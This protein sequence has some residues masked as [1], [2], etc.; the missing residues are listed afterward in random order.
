MT[1]L[2]PIAAAESRPL[3]L[4]WRE[5]APLPDPVGRKG[6]FAGVSHGHGLLAG[7]SNFPVP[8]RAGGKKTF[9][10]TVYVCPLPLADSTRW[11]SVPD[12]L[13]SPL[14][15]GASVVTEKGIACLG[16][17]D[18]TRPV[19]SAFL[20]TWNAMA[21]TVA[22]NALPD[23][24]TASA[25]AAATTFAG[26]I[27]VAGGES[28]DG[29]LATFWRLD[30]ARASAGAQWETLLA[31]PG[32]PRFGAFLLKVATPSGPRL[33]FGGGL[34]GPAKT[35]ADYLRDAWLFDPA[36]RTWSAAAGL[37]RGAVLAATLAIDATRAV[38]LGGSDGHDFARMKEL[39]ERYRIPSD[40]LLYDAAAD[41]WSVAGTM[42]LGVVGAA[43]VQDGE[44]WLV[45][46]G[47]YSPGLRTAGVYAL[48]VRAR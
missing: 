45:A 44:D 47:E 39:G 12:A 17:H 46:G 31:W 2:L 42:P 8:Q 18:G 33:L 22:R 29:A 28:A 32:G 30:L 35:Q 7:G 34:P 11:T 1:L 43:V 36:A 3:A 21:R 6:M 40:V 10:R 24:P 41:R 20:L 13:A 15:E 27:Y 37:P 26:S 9:H 25:N 4:Q 16:G 19:A 23:L 38:V 14:G 5:L 48:R